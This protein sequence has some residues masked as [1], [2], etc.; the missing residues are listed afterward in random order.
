MI[1]DTCIQSQYI[2][3]DGQFYNRKTGRIMKKYFAHLHGYSGFYWK[4]C[5]RK[6][7]DN[8]IAYDLSKWSLGDPPAG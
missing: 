2:Y 8:Y 6:I 4:L 5:G 1:C 7:Y 3:K